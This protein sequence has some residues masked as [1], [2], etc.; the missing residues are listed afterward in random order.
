[1]TFFTKTSWDVYLEDQKFYKCNEVE[2]KVR[3]MVDPSYVELFAKLICEGYLL[4]SN[5]A[6]E[7][8]KKNRL[9][10]SNAY[11]ILNDTES[12]IRFLENRIRLD[13]EN[14]F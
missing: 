13:E 1:M 8:F 9:D 4:E 5:S 7:F 11:A 12:L 10:E 3:M 2:D 6:I 14:E